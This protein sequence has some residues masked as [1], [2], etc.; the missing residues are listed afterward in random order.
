MH[1]R[2]GHA[3]VAEVAHRRGDRRRHVEELEVEEH[4]L[5]AADHPVDELE[6]PAGGEQLEADLVERHRV[7]ERLREPARRV[8]ARHVH[9]E[10]QALARGDDGSGHAGSGRGAHA[11]KR[12]SCR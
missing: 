12:R 6:R 3:A 11:I 1:R 10:D 8:R 7:A 2:E 4:A 9:R 5:A